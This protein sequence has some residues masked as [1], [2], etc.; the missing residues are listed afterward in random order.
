M[1][2][3]ASIAKDN[4]DKGIFLAN[5]IYEE[6]LQNTCLQIGPYHHHNRKKVLN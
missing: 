3:W 5:L 6:G 4:M 2:K 1:I